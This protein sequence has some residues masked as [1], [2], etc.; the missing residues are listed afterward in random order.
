MSFLS[1]EEFKLL[2]NADLDKLYDYLTEKFNALEFKIEQQTQLIHVQESRIKELEAR[3]NQ[4]SKNSHKPPSSDIFKKERD[5]KTSRRKSGGQTGHEGSNLKMVSNPTDIKEYPAPENCEKCNQSL[6]EIQVKSKV[7]QEYT[8]PKMEMSIIE[9]RVESKKCSC[10]HINTKT[11]APVIKNHAYY[12]TEFKSFILYL[13][14]YHM[15]PF[16]RIK[17]L[18]KDVFGHT[19]SE[20]TIWNCEKELSKKLLPIEDTIKEEI[21][22]GNVACFD[23]T[24]TRSEKKNFWVHVAVN[25]DFSHFSFHNKRGFDGMIAGGIL[26]NFKG[27]AVHDFFKP[28][29]KFECKHSFCNAHLLRELIGAHET[30]KQVWTEMMLGVLITGLDARKESNS[31]TASMD[32]L[33][34]YD[35]AIL[36]GF[37][38]NPDI[39]IGKRRSSSK[40]VNLLKRMDRYK[41]GI[42]KFLFTTDVPFDNNLAERAL[43]MF[44]V[45]NKI[46]GCFRNSQ[47]GDF[48]CRLRSFLDTCKKQK[49][50]ILESINEVFKTGNFQ[51]CR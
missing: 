5:R 13:K 19:V 45:K 17:E 20:G 51:F 4:N 46:S 11:D 27:T 44:K 1:R 16:A 35:R 32:I 9:H 14:N 3:L 2:A 48:F 30:T 8:L 24:G 43:R 12:G 36:M 18:I 38:E 34:M 47:S 25:P 31:E 42:L 50:P 33:K 39:D 28:Y 6:L 23:E 49:L 37:Q 15:L 41:E 10:G 22:N 26:P 21:M 7:G 29:L 40:V